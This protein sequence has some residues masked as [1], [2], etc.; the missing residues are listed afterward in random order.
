MSFSDKN[1]IKR[2]L[3]EQPFYNVAIEKPKITKFNNVD[4]L[5]EL[6]FYDEL[7]VVKATK[8]FKQICK[9]L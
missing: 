3:K 7:N 8:T 5:R 9:K 6:M 1:E 2:L 4:M